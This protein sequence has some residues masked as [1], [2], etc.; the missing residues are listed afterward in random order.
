VILDH[1]LMN[2]ILIR[3]EH[4]EYTGF[5]PFKV[6][7]SDPPSEKLYYQYLEEEKEIASEKSMTCMK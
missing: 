1:E 3:S 7:I 6:L 4:I 2:L 5:R